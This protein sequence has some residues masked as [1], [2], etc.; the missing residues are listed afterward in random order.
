MISFDDTFRRQLHE[1]FVWRRDVRRFRRD[2]LP[3]GTLERLIETACLSP[4][5][6]LSQPWRFVIV[7]DKPRRS[8]VIEDFRA[9][10]ADALQSYSGERAAKYAALKLSGLEEA[11]GH[12]AVFAEK[13]S[14]IGSGLGRATMP[15]TTEYSVVAAICS[16]WLAAR[17]EGIG[18]GW[19][20]ILNPARVNDILEVPES[21][22]FIGYLCIG[23]PEAECDRPE[24]EQAKWESRRSSGEFTVRR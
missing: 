22:K 8:A 14:S 1:L 23:Y 3:A 18:L 11:P 4:S 21:W 20:S 9:C 6:G 10:N 17:A 15:E 16:M 19:V 13:T 2:P 7:E 24:L 5:V 12:L